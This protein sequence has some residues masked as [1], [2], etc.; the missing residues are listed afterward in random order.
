[1]VITFSYIHRKNKYDEI[2]QDW[3]QG[4]DVKIET[5]IKMVET[6]MIGYDHK[7]DCGNQLIK[8]NGCRNLYIV[9]VNK[10]IIKLNHLL[11][12]LIIFIVFLSVDHSIYKTQSTDCEGYTLS[13]VF[14]KI[15]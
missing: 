5:I 13:L 11:I 9:V 3:Y 2:N 7:Y 14:Y 10:R 4:D 6:T 12:A 8:S 1:M 15:V